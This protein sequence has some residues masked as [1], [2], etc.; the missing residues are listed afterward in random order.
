MGDE[1]FVSGMFYC[2]AQSTNDGDMLPNSFTVMYNSVP[3]EAAIDII[4][5]KIADEIS[6]L[7]I[8]HA[9]GSLSFKAVHTWQDF[10]D[11][12]INN[13]VKTSA[14]IDA[15]TSSTLVTL[16]SHAPE[17]LGCLHEKWEAQVD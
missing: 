8:E 12:D 1:D 15:I 4:M 6:E 9:T 10:A 2:G 14:L 7:D 13:A 5:N 16:N 3:L 11:I 17:I